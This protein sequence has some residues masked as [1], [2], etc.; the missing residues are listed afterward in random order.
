MGE[1]RG[2]QQTALRGGEKGHVLP[3][4][5]SPG[6]ER[7]GCLSQEEVDTMPDAAEGQVRQ[8]RRSGHL[9]SETDVPG[10]PGEGR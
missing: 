2:H 9:F 3:Q 8:G 1:R 10:S 7:R 6:T 5:E 4:G